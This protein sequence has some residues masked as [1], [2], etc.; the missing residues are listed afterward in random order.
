MKASTVLSHA[1]LLLATIAAFHGPSYAME[2][3][4][5]AQDG[6]EILLNY[7]VK[8]SSDPGSSRPITAVYAKPLEI[9]I[10]PTSSLQA[11]DRVRA[12]LINRENFQGMCGISSYVRDPHYVMD[13]SLIPNSSSFSG[14][15]GSARI[16]LN[17]SEVPLKSEDQR[18]QLKLDGYCFKLTTNQE[19][20]VVINGTWL[21]DPVSGTHNFKFNLL[22]GLRP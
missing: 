4:L 11:S 14:E 7:D 20:A 21:V 5:Q 3:R 18:V 22:Q 2:I 16:L 19:L 17:G 13:L 9:R 10:T 6:T 12:V 15:F 8:A 1:L